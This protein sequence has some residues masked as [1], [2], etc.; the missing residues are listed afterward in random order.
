MVVKEKTLDKTKIFE[1]CNADQQT[2]IEKIVSEYDVLF[3][4]PKGLPPK[5]GI[6]HDIILQQDVPFLNIGMYRLS[7]LENV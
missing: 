4:E 5:K 1:G 3:Q 6:V 2:D 7:S